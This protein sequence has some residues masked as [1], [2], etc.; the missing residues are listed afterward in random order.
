[1]SQ[2]SPLS[3]AIAQSLTAQRLMSVEKEQQMRRAQVL[4]KNV[5]ARDDELGHQVESSG[6]VDPVHD[7]DHHPA[8]QQPGRDSSQQ[9]SDANKKPHI[10]VTA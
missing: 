9:E 6:Q 5:A 1:M 10:D 8:G 4:E 3:N 7:E 2:I